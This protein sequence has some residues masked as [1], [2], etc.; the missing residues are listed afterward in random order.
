MAYLARWRLS[1]AADV[2]RESDA[3]LDRVAREVGYGST[4]AF[5]AAFKRE[6]GM[7]PSQFRLTEASLR[8]H[9][10]EL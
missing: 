10:S 2:R 7:S 5:S 8:A 4:F 6:W 1:L 9:A 3:T